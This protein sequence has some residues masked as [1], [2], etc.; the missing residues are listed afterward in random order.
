[1][2]HVSQAAASAAG[3]ATMTQMTG[4][5]AFV[6]AMLAVVVL[7]R[8]I[9]DRLGVPYTIILT[10]CGLI[11]AA[12]PG[13]NLQLEPDIVLFLVIPPLL[14]AAALRSSLLAIRADWRPIASLSVVLVLITAFA[15]GALAA[16]VVPQLTLA[17][18]VV[19]GSAV[20]PT[21]P[22]ASLSIGG[23]A[24]LPSRLLTLIGG[25]GL[26][27][28]GTALTTYQV[29]VAATV[30]GGFSLAVAAGKFV[31]AV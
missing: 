27:N 30:G 11:Y 24:G 1:M 4:Q 17:A 22:V 20:A 8:L 9:S 18:G 15:V 23:R 2:P 6:L 14:Y 12:L 3:S 28:D 19:L 29:A 13:P 7:A 21:D 5:I 25:E 31:L 16:W 10:I 26:L